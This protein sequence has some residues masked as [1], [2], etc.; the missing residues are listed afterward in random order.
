MVVAQQYGLTIMLKKV[1][2]NYEKE[3]L[4]YYNSHNYPFNRDWDAYNN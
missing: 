3:E 2:N 4:V 1:M